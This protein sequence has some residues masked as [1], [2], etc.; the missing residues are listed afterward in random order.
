MSAVTKTISPAAR[1]FISQI[2]EL[3]AFLGFPPEARIVEREQRARAAERRRRQAAKAEA[4]KEKAQQA[5]NG[6]SG[7]FQEVENGVSEADTKYTDKKPARKHT[8]SDTKR[9]INERKNKWKTRGND[10]DVHIYRLDNGYWSLHKDVINKESSE[11]WDMVKDAEAEHQHTNAPAQDQQE[12]GTTG[13][14]VRVDLDNFTINMLQN[15]FYFMYHYEYQHSHPIQ[16]LSN[17]PFSWHLTDAYFVVFNIEMYIASR[18]FKIARLEEYSLVHL[19]KA[20][21]TFSSCLKTGNI[22]GDPDASCRRLSEVL[23]RRI[24]GMNGTTERADLRRLGQKMCRILD[25][26]ILEILG[27]DPTNFDSEMMARE[28]TTTSSSPSS[29]LE[30]HADNSEHSVVSQGAVPDGSSNMSAENDERAWPESAY[31]PAKLMAP[32]W[33]GVR[34]TVSVPL[35]RPSAFEDGRD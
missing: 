11:L 3:V 17:N 26:L 14:L 13:G 32:G 27:E 4:N 20:F 10:G 21:D 15:V 22:I 2:S 18:V 34:K 9:E 5:H 28:S 6:S 25:M 12:N 33:S 19:R 7:L 29:S 1:R 24:D 23:L 16:R 31:P 35:I 8:G 30:T